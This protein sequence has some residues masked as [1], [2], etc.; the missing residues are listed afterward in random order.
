[1][2]VFRSSEDILQVPLK[3]FLLPGLHCFPG[4]LVSDHLTYPG[5]ASLD[6]LWS[7]FREAA[8][9]SLGLPEIASRQKTR[10]AIIRL[11]SFISLFSGIT[12][13]YHLLS[14]ALQK[15]ILLPSFLIIY[16]GWLSLVLVITAW[17][18]VEVLTIYII[19]LNICNFESYF[20]AF[21]ETY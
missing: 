16:Y 5:L 4:H 17:L 12:I 18:E 11:A 10:P 8:K 9:L 1:M 19:F 2:T 14:N 20:W 6:H 15:V 21:L 13:V 3:S 7:Q